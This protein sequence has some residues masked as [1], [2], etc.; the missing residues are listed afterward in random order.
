MKDRAAWHAA[1]HEGAESDTIQSL[2][3]N[4]KKPKSY[5]PEFKVVVE[6]RGKTKYIFR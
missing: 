4:K 1:V 6:S 2:N 5:N 3:N